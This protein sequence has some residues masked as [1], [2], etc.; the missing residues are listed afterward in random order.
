MRVIDR[1]SETLDRPCKSE[2]TR[3]REGGPKTKEKREDTVNR[4]RRVFVR[5]QGME[6]TN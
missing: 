2:R 3:V 1:G 6:V 4:N 5:I